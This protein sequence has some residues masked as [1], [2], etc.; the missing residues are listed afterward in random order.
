MKK[1]IYF[2]PALLLG[3]V[4]SACQTTDI[5]KDSLF[6]TED[7]IQKILDSEPNGY[8]LYD[9]AHG[10]LNQFV[11]DYM[12]EKG[13]FMSDSSL[14]RTRSNG[15]GHLSPNE[16]LDTVYVFSIDTLPTNGKAL[17]IRGRVTT[18]D[19]GGNFYKS[20]VIQ[21]IVNGKQQ[22]LR[23]SV[24]IGS[25][26]GLYV[27]GQELLIRVNGLAIGRYANQVQ[28]CVP[29]MSNNLNSQYPDQKCGWAPG[30]I[31]SSI[32][33]KAVTLCGYPDKSKL[34][35]ESIKIADYID[36][37]NLVEARHLD[38]MLV[39]IENVHFTGQYSNYGDLANC[40]TGNPEDDQNANV[41]APTTNNLG[42]PQSR[43]FVDADGNHSLVSSSEYAKYAH[44]YL[45]DA[46]YWG[47]VEGILS[48]YHDN[49]TVRLYSGKDSYAPDWDDW[50][51]SIRDLGDIQ[52]VDDA[53]NPW[54]PIEYSTK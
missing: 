1:Y 30:R 23:L 31:P 11:D 41:F 53:G 19:Y 32:F 35:Y 51:I 50:A 18:D 13:N 27:I 39:R 36:K 44:F 52:L 25:V 9:E 37:L 48:L 26:G 16:Y 40:T 12:T 6:K 42:F 7:E 33:Q 28:L 54:I 17:Y 10:G 22:N 49:N 43:V 21:Q 5:D 45:P 24:D 34:V 4:L 20:L 8:Y 46:K 2:I 29:S 14:Y 38:G 3:F 15:R 47:S